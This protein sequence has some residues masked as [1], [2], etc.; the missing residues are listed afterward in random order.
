MQVWGE[1]V[2]REMAAIIYVPRSPAE[3]AAVAAFDR[4]LRDWFHG[5]DAGWLELTAAERGL[6]VHDL[7]HALR[8]VQLEVRPKE[9]TRAGTDAQRLDPSRP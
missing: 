9:R 8:A 2:L 6:I 7:M 1:A 4:V 3:A 5:A